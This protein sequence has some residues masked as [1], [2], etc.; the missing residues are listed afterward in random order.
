MK[1][2]IKIINERIMKII[3][4][5]NAKNNERKMKIVSSIKIISKNKQSKKN[6][7]T[8]SS[9]KDQHQNEIIVNENEIMK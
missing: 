6:Q 9:K 3:D 7:S 5:N 4:N 2:K 1:W 8:A